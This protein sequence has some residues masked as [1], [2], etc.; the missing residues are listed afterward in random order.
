MRLLH[1]IEKI[2]GCVTMS[3]QKIELKVCINCRKCQRNLMKAVTKHSGIDEISVDAEKD[4]LTVIGEIDPVKV[5]K[6]IKKIKKEADIITV[7]PPEKPEN[8]ESKKSDDKDK[9]KPLP[10]CCHDCQLITIGYGYE[11]GRVCTIL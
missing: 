1:F 11:D 5:V 8:K 4:I 6:Q 7:G 2:C 9:P 10:P 3:I